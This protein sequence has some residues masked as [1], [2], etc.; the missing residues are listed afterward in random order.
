MAELNAARMKCGTTRITWARLSKISVTWQPSNWTK[1]TENP[2][3]W[4]STWY[5]GK[6]F[7]KSSRVP[8]SQEL[9]PLSSARWLLKG[10]DFSCKSQRKAPGGM[11][12]IRSSADQSDPHRGDTREAGATV[13]CNTKLRDLNIGVSLQDERAIEVM[14]SGLPFHQGAQLPVDITLRSAT[15]AAGLPCTNVACTNGAQWSVIYLSWRRNAGGCAC[16]L[17]HVLARSRL[18][19]SPMWT[20]GPVQTVLCRIWL[21]CSGRPDLVRLPLNFSSAIGQPRN[22]SADPGPEWERRWAWSAAHD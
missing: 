14:A 20:L 1:P 15:T 11:S 17:F 12:T 8:Y 5:I 9:N 4:A 3:V 22:T 2:R 16:C 6:R 18:A 10:C 21:T 7:C 19:W 13:R